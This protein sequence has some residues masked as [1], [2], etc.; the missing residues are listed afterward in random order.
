MASAG[1]SGAV[2]IAGRLQCRGSLIASG[3]VPKSNKK[4]IK[5]TQAEPDATTSMSSSKA[6]I[7]GDSTN[8]TKKPQLREAEDEDEQLLRRVVKAGAGT[9]R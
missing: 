9:D 7:P 8:V 3:S 6:T 5:Q 1:K 4:P 2:D